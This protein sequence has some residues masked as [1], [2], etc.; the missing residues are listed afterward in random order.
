MVVHNLEGWTFIPDL[1]A[2]FKNNSA[3]AEVRIWVQQLIVPLLWK[4]RRAT[5]HTINL[6][7]DNKYF[8]HSF[9]DNWS[10]TSTELNKI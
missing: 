5:P 7:L 2:L 9:L 6:S 3:E 4:G 10:K 1:N 8:S